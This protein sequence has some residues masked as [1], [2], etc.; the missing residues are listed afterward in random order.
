MR[1]ARR[2]TRCFRAVYKTDGTFPARVKD[3]NHIYWRILDRR[4]QPNPSKRVAR[5][6]PTY[7]TFAIS[8]CMCGMETEPHQPKTIRSKYIGD[9]GVWTKRTRPCRQGREREMP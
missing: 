4:V 6:A 7:R 3:M 8:K 9:D 5:S 1:T 2:S